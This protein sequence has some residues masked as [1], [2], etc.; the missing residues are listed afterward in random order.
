MNDFS[1]IRIIRR[2]FRPLKRYYLA[3]RERE[4]F[5]KLLHPTDV[6]IVGHPKS[7]NTLMSYMLA[8]LLYKD[9]GAQINLTNMGRYIPQIHFE[10][11][12]IG[13]Y[14]DIS[15]P[16]L[17]R[18]EA[19]LYPELYPNVIYLVRDPRAVLVS[20]YHMYCTI[21]DD[22]TTT[23]ENFVDEYLLNGC[24]KRYEP[25]IDR[26]DKQV[27]TWVKRSKKDGRVM[28]MRYEDI[29]SDKMAALRKAAAFT[30]I[31]CSEDCFDLAL[32]RSSFEAMQK[33]ETNHGTSAYLGEIGKR[34]HFI[35]KGQIDGWKAEL[36]PALA[37][38]IETTFYNS[39]L[40][41]DYLK[42]K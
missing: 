9:Y 31:S 23:I 33:L 19:P 5:R 28:L 20:Y 30:G 39:M 12:S 17:F 1:A 6:F 27:S 36:S 13:H 15:M 16:R 4:R 32:S 14:E 38:K 35:R 25:M 2:P 22:K 18:N 24:I 26:W 37:K 8:T 3:H 41:L 29:L 10:D 40:A 21:F 11:H 7:G 42:R 34:G